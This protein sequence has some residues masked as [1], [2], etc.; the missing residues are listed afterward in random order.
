MIN[1]MNFKKLITGLIM[2][3]MWS[4][5]TSAYCKGSDGAIRILAIGNSFSEDAVENYLWDIAAS[6]GKTLIIGNMYIPGCPLERH[7][8]NARADKA[9]YR[10]R[11]TGKDGIRVQKDKVALSEALADEDWDYVSFQQASPLSGLYET[12]EASLPELVSYVRERVPKK[13]KFILQDR[14]SVV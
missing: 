5:A 11:K 14:K 12:W 6:D 2:A 3:F 10:Y 8:G 9:E 13:T 7:L 1:D 4:V